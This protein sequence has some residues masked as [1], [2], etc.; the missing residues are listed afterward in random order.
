MMEDKY[1]LG[2]GVKLQDSNI[3][4]PGYTVSLENDY[5]SRCFK[6]KNYGEYQMSTKSNEEYLK[7]LKDVSETKDLVLYLVDVLNIER[8]LNEIRNY[9][10]NRILLIVT[11]RDVMPLSV[12]DEKIKD[13]FKKSGLEYEDII[14]I[15]S[16]KNYNLDELFFMIKKYKS[17]KNVYVV[18]HTNAGKSA[19]INKILDN[20]TDN[21][22][23]LTVSSL[24]STTLDKIEIEISDD[25][26][27]IDTPGLIDIGNI[28]N[29]VDPKELKR[30]H[31][32]K[33]IKPRT[34]QVKE[35]Q[36][37]IIDNYARIDY[38][39]GDRNSLTFFIS[40]DLELDKVGFNNDRLKD[41]SSNEYE[42]G[43]LED[44]VINGLGFIKIIE[45]CKVRVYVNKEVQVFTRSSLI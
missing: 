25:L 19:L 4:N 38:L 6:L 29:Y 1:C 27:I 40:N 11:K 43:Y 22:R 34:H 41:L 37:L 18:G 8:D 23:E 2:C 9:L 12:S 17:S 31:P 32:K 33:E 21:S 30:I 35:G 24:P 14:L 15:S 5:C 20:Y 45:K 42:V 44:L 39:E 3:L 26:K 10:S 13:Y 16:N 28:S 36:S 7:I